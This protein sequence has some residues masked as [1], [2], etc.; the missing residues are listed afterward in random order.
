MHHILDIQ[1]LGDRH[2]IAWLHDELD[3]TRVEWQ[4]SYD[5]IESYKEEH[6]CKLNN[7]VMLVVTDG[8]A[9]NAYERGQMADQFPVASA[10]V[11]TVLTN[12]IK[13]GIATAIGWTNPR[14]LFTEPK[15]WQRALEHIGIGEFGEQLWNCYRELQKQ[16]PLNKTLEL[17]SRACA[18]PSVANVAVNRP[19]HAKAP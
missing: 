17:I 15:Q 6:S 7:V 4:A 10:V 16:M 11:T 2:V 5:K 9:P 13:R 3:P 19:L 14:F 12:P 18:L 8:G 1:R